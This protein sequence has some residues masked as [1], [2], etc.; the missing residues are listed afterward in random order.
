M[1]WL[2]NNESSLSALAAIIAI[3]AGVAV[4][5]RLVWARMPGKVISNVTH[6]TFLS[7]WRNL[8]LISLVFFGVALLSILT[9]SNGDSGKPGNSGTA[10][11]GKPSVAV[12]P[13]DYVSDDQTR[14]YLADAIAEDV[15][16]LLSRNP[17]FFVV[18]R[19][20]SFTYRG[21]SVDIR[22][23]GEELNVNY[24]VEGSVRNIAGRLRVTVQLI[25]TSNGQHVW[26]EKYDRPLE[27]VFALQDE[28][29]NGIAAA[30]GDEIYRAEIARASGTSTENLDA[31]GLVMRANRSLVAFNS[32]S[33][34]EAIPP[35]RAA[36]AL[37]PDY[38]LARAELA[39]ALCYRGLYRWSDTP[40]QDLTEAYE[41][42]TLALQQAPNDPLVLYAM[43]SCY[44]YTGR[45]LEG[46]RL[47]EHA[48]AIQPNFAQALV[49][50]GMAMTFDDRPE[51]GLSKIELAL[52]LSPRSPYLHRA[53]SFR[54]ITLNELSRYAEGEQAANNAIKSFDG[55]YYGWI[56]LAWAYAGQG[57]QE[58]AVKALYAA[59]KAEP[60]LTL[61]FVK[62]VMD[63]IDKNK[64]GHMFS[65]LEPIWPED[66]LTADSTNE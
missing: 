31:W 11:T 32:K 63:P 7:D 61:D 34:N 19:N 1:D 8:A 35:L 48:I 2:A 30:L 13:L 56:A 53:E 55:W 45:Q 29:T 42:G 23:V 24:V 57:D 36:L 16:T 41:L 60:L 22:Q 54:A 20:S 38:I 28:I 3:I 4:V 5:T 65:L 49:A 9:L 50:L 15:I 51:Q 46:I 37:D 59:K 43:G 44:G 52:K 10:I 66:L 58:A 21:Q 18:A 39:R 17:R 12:L 40:E 14:A 6:P 62:K 64:S 25:N 27:E 26:A 47:L 33:A